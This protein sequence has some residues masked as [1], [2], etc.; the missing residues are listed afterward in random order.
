[1]Q[2]LTIK[3]P[4]SAGSGSASTRETVHLQ[5]PYEYIHLA[6]NTDFLVPR[7][8]FRHSSLAL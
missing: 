3:S 5:S 1:M 6:D 8:P 7:S 4:L 2:N